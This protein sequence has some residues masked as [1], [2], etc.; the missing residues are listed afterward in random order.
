MLQ[1]DHLHH[2]NRSICKS[3]NDFGKELHRQNNRKAKKIKNP[4]ENQTN[5]Q[6]RLIHVHMEAL[7]A[8]LQL[9]ARGFFLPCVQS[10]L[11]Q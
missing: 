8:W 5:Y 9:K 11:Q 4:Q 1:L 10:L 6:R 7:Q 3:K 2:L